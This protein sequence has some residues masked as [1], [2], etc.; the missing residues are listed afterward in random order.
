MTARSCAKTIVDR[1]A[2]KYPMI[3]HGPGTLWQDILFG[4][5]LKYGDRCSGP[6]RSC[7][8]RAG[9]QLAIDQRRS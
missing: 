5:G 3:N 7:A 4:S 2:G 8:R 1:L 9:E 6:K